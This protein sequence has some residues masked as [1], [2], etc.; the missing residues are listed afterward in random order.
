L[1][2]FHTYQ[3]NEGPRLN[4]VCHGFVAFAL[5][6]L[7][8]Y[9]TTGEARRAWRTAGFMLLQGL[10]AHYHLL[11]GGLVLGLVLLGALAARPRVVARRLPLPCPAGPGARPACPRRPGPPPRRPWPSSSSCSRWGRTSSSGAP[12]SGPALIGSSIAGCPAS[13]SSA[14]PSA[15]PSWPCCSSPSSPAAVSA[16][17]RG[18]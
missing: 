1:Y 5:A 10:S 6:E 13:S 3:I 9:L 17:S 15:S 4:I 8:L 7:V 12:T 14:S 18:G 16:S 2:G 11:Y